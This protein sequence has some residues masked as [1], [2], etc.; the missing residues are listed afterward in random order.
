[1]ATHQDLRLKTKSAPKAS[2]SA[3]ISG[4]SNQ[5]IIAAIAYLGWFITGIAI[6]LIEKQN[7]YI[8]FHAM[9][10]TVFSGALFLANI[11]LGFIPFFGFWSGQILTM[12][13]FIVWIVL[14]YKAFTGEEYELPYFGAL[15]RRQLSRF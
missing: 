2:S 9:Q 12:I 5:N 8:R 3:G 11:A 6:L 15:A 4:L 13:G 10:S 1:M 14:L 7:R